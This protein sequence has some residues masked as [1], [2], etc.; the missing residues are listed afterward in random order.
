MRMTTSSLQSEQPIGPL[1]HLSPLLTHSP[2]NFF[3]CGKANNTYHYKISRRDLS[4]SKLSHWAK[5]K[6]TK[7]L[8]V[9]FQTEQPWTWARK[10]LCLEV[11]FLIQ[12][13]ITTGESWILFESNHFRIQRYSIWLPKS[14]SYWPI[15]CNLLGAQRWCHCWC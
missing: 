12:R 11:T 8:R 7:Y 1:W 4:C 3:K 13:W 6:E 9:N 5:K 10:Y 14:A 2:Y 15:V